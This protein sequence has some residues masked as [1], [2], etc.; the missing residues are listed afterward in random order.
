LKKYLTIGGCILLVVIA[1]VSYGVVH[2]GNVQEDFWRNFVPSMLANVVGVGVGAIIGV[3]I[4]LAINHY[5]TVFSGH[6][7]LRQRIA[8]V[9][10]LLEQVRVELSAHH[11]RLT[12][13][14][15]VFPIGVQATPIT[16]A[17]QPT[18]PQASQNLRNLTAADVIPLMLTDAVGQQF[19][20]NR[21][22]LEIK[23]TQILFHV[24]N[25]YTRVGD[26]NRLLAWRSQDQAHP[27][28]WDG[29]ISDM[30]FTLAST[31]AQLDH[32]IQQTLARLSN[33]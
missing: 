30:V 10:E 22:V 24:S 4:G 19:L 14:S 31:R 18:A 32:D 27:E 9:R 2:F 7:H 17:A 12:Q 23:E 29:R 33:G 28:N 6:Q 8:E 13:L 1:A 15:A 5:I 25:Y 26:I 16:V 20:S 21:S 11:T 3:P